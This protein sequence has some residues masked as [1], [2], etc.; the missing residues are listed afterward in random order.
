MG[1]GKAADVLKNGRVSQ[2]VFIS[3]DVLKLDAI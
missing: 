1:Y 2:D 3:Q